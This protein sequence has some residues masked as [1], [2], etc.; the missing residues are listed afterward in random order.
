ML[1]EE[2][3]RE[4]NVM[5]ATHSHD[6]SL[7]CPRCHLTIT[8]KAPWLAARFCPRCLAGHHMIVEMLS[9][10]PVEDVSALP[11]AAADPA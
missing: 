4:R 2:S 8:P 3:P 11:R 5:G 1:L 6:L 9:Y 7:M 10:A